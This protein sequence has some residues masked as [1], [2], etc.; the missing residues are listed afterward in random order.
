MSERRQQQGIRILNT[1]IRCVGIAVCGS[2]GFRNNTGMGHRVY[3]VLVHSCVGFLCVRSVDQNQFLCDECACAFHVV[4]FGRFCWAN[5]ICITSRQLRRQQRARGRDCSRLNG[6]GIICCIEHHHHTIS[7]PHRH[8]NSFTVHGN[9]INSTSTLFF[10]SG[11]FD[12]RSMIGNASLSLNFI[13]LSLYLFVHFSDWLRFPGRMSTE[14]DIDLRVFAC[15]LEYIYVYVC[16]FECSC[17]ECSCRMNVCTTS[18]RKSRS[19]R[20]SS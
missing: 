1:C 16:T 17:R 15:I 5:P 7:R 14:H 12:N 3:M 18:L 11:L 13:P 20:W 6:I 8:R 10:V 9:I 2:G 4:L 19:L